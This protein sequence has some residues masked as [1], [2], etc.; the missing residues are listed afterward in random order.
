M[1]GAPPLGA[2][3]TGAPEAAPLPPPAT[4]VLAGGAPPGPGPG[5]S[6][7]L[8][9]SGVGLHPA[10]NAVNAEAQSHARARRH[11]QPLQSVGIG[12]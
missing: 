10:E 5:P 6:D 11:E 4:G 3:V 9:V 7:G 1:I 12:P 8:P 2:G